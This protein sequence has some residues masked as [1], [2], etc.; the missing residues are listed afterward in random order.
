MKEDKGNNKIVFGIIVLIIAI[1]VMR[2][3]KINH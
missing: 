2:N 1:F 3:Q